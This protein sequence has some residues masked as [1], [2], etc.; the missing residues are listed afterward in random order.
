MHLSWYRFADGSLAA[1]QDVP[2]TPKQSL[3]IDPRDVLG[4][5]DETQY[6]VVVDGVNGT[7]TGIVVE[8]NFQ[9]GDGAMIY[10]GFPR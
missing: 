4:L 1:S 10:E 7:L 8:L 9:G 6:A 2:I 5:V 3:R